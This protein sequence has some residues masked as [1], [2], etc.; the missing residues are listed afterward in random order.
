MELTRVSAIVEHFPRGLLDPPECPVCGGTAR[1]PEAL[2]CWHCAAGHYA[3]CR[4]IRDVALRLPALTP[5]EKR[6]W[7]RL[8]RLLPNDE[9]LRRLGTPRNR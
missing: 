1:D 6:V 7:E 5:A 4:W 8:T 2:A 3:D 9:V